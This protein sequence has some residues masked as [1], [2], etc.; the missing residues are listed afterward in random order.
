[1]LSRCDLLVHNGKEHAVDAEIW[2]QDG[3]GMLPDRYWSGEEKSFLTSSFAAFLGGIWEAAKDRI[4]T[5]FGAVA[6][7]GGKNA[8]LG[9]L[10]GAAQNAQNLIAE[11]GRKKRTVSFVNS[12]RRVRVFLNKSLD[13]KEV[14][15]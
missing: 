12:G 5:P 11:D 14:K 8:V 6:G 1:M 10:T 7:K 3:G 9:G 15:P 4:A 13:L 2:D